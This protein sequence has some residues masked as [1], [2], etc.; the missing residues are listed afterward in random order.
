[1]VKGPLLTNHKPSHKNTHLLFKCTPGLHSEILS[2]EKERERE[3]KEGRRK[4]GG[5]EGGR[6]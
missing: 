5:R 3:R 6:E 2:K 1:M 4:E